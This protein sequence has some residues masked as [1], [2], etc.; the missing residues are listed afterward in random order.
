MSS[1]ECGSS[2]TF[3][4]DRRGAVLVEFALALPLLMLII[5]GILDF[6]L[7]FQRQQVVTNAAR[8]GARMAV[9]HGYSVTD[10]KQRVL[11]YL[12]AGGVPLPEEPEESEESEESEEPTGFA[13]VSV[14][15]VPVTPPSGTPYLWQVTVEV[16][17]SLSFVGLFAPTFGGSFGE[18]TLRGVSLM[19]AET[20]AGGT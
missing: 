1:R 8:E 3:T 18:L 9:L 14:T 11:D 7:L 6:G 16:P 5:V 15:R 4:S 10:V 12:V 17:Y 19:R 2:V 20:A 13:L